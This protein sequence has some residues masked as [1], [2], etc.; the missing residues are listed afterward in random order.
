TR[1][2][3]LSCRHCFPGSRCHMSSCFWLCYCRFPSSTTCRFWSGRY[4][5]L[6]CYSCFLTWN[7]FCRRSVLLGFL[8]GSSLQGH[9]FRVAN[10]ILTS[11]RDDHQ[12]PTIRTGIRDGTLPDGEIAGWI[13]VASIE[14]TLF[15]LGLALNQIATTLR[16][17]STRFIDEGTT[18]TAFREAG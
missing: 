13:V 16:A 9:N 7:T 3:F 2:S 8:L 15:L 1:C 11:T 6:I 17:Q 12:T 10:R 18:I 4:Y 5:L 14:D